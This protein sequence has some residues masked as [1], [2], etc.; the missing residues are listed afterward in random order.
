MNEAVIPE[1]YKTIL[2]ECGCINYGYWLQFIC[3]I[4]DYQMWV[5]LLDG[6]QFEI[7]GP[8]AQA[9]QKEVHHYGY[10]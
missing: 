1:D 5:Y 4:C 9:N 6:E 8:S 7:M 2:H 3:P 10:Q